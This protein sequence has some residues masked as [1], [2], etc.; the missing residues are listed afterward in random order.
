VRF[1]ID[2]A[3][4]PQVAELLRAAGHDAIHVR[5]R[6]MGEAEDERVIALAASE[7]RVIVSAD[8]DFGTM[9]VLRKA[10]RPSVI[11]F[12]RGSPRRPAW[13][14][15]SLLANLPAITEDLTQ[16]AIAVFRG[17]RIRVRRL[18]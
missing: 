8:T 5:D 7:E 2:N 6:A 11:I 3:V 12:R 16:G 10:P 4:S 1:L 9:L 17:D 18:P 13:Q 14:A 15:E